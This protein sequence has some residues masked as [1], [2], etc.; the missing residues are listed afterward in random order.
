MTEHLTPLERAVAEQLQSAHGLDAETAARRAAD[1]TPRLAPRFAT[2]VR[3]ELALV[4]R[5]AGRRQRA[6]APRQEAVGGR[7]FQRFS[8][9]VR[10]QHAVMA[11]SVII[12]ILTGLPLKFSN[13]AVAKAIIGVF[14]GPDVSPIV[15]RVAASFL[16]AVGVWHLA[17]ISATR[18]GR[19]TFMLLLP[20]LQD[21]KD[22]WQQIRYF[23]GRTDERPRFDKFSYVEK[24]D[25]WAVYWGMVIMIGSGTVLWFTDQFLKVFPK[26]FTDIAKEAHSDEALLATLAIVVWHFYNVHLNPHKFPMNRTFI[27]GRISE[28]EMI[29]EHPREWERI[30]SGAPLGAADSRPVEPKGGA[31]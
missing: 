29:E 22:A 13:L 25:Y 3:R 2:W 27:T 28:H 26:W 21:A 8:L 20:R 7:E 15:H 5:S 18:E 30:T 12:L 31:R 23:L 9:N 16:I 6:A 10:L 24:F 11:L 19:S 4:E 14:G 17:F 1:M